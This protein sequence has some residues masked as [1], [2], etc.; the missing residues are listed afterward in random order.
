MTLPKRKD[1]NFK[2][3]PH[4]DQAPE[5]KGL[6]CVQGLLN[7]APAGPKDGGLLLMPGSSALFEE[8]FSTFKAR[9]RT[10]VEA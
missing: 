10:D 2:P 5:R 3:W 6:A 1:D 7:L 4:C 8:Y 9:G